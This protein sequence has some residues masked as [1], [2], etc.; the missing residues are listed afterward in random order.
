MSGEQ[1][2]EN[3]FYSRDNFLPE[4]EVERVKRSDLTSLEQTIDEQKIKL[5]QLTAEISLLKGQQCSC[6]IFDRMKSISMNCL[7]LTT[8]YFLLVT[9]F[10]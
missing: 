2:G 4:G 3:R 8:K 7:L 10:Y 5:Q 9:L 6:I 1:E